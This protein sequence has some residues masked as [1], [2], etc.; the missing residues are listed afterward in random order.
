MIPEVNGNN[1]GGRK[2]RIIPPI[3]GDIICPTLDNELFTPKI[4]PTTLQ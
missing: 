4:L 3:K 2:S 1:G